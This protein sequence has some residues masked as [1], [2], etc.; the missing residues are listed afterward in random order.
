MTVVAHLFSHDSD[1]PKI[2]INMARDLYSILGVKRD[3]SAQEIKKAYRKI[4]QENHPD[5]NP[6]PAA[7]ERFKEASAAFDVIGN[8]DKRALY[9]EF[10]PDGLREG[11]NPDAARQYGTGFGGGAGGFGNF[12]DILSQI[13]GGGGFGGGGFGGGGFG[14][15]GFGGFQQPPQRGANLQMKLKITLAEAIEGG[16]RQLPG[17]GKV[18]IPASVNSGQKLRL[19]G[20]GQ[21]GPGGTGDMIVTLEVIVP[22]GFEVDDADLGHM[23]VAVPITLPQAMFGAKIPVKLPEGGQV[24]L[25]LP[26]GL[27][28]PKRMRIPR[29]GMTIKGGRGHLY[30]APYIYAPLL[31]DDEEDSAKVRELM[32][33]LQSYYP[34]DESD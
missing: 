1:N 7:E 24:T 10:G 31:P 11:F 29:R 21:R 22:H 32:D 6:D 33:Q 17:K 3:A 18:T 4:A 20:K 28:L 2:K 14:G 26:A 9:D 16:S 25:T 12:D 19:R 15:G 34:S 30:V 13:F 5:R 27:K 23:S 8:S